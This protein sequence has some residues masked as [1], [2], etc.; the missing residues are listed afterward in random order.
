MECQSRAG[1]RM[2]RR[3]R[4]YTGTPARMQQPPPDHEDASTRFVRSDD[5]GY[6]ANLAALWAADATLAAAIEALPDDADY[7]VE[8]SKTGPPTVCLPTPDGKSIYLHSRYR[9][10]EEAQKLIDA[11]PVDDRA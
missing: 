4:K 1:N 3:R 9:P 5:A 7:A 6:V 10:V 8:P 11:V 2:R